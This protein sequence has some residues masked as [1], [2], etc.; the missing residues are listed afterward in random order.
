MWRRYARMFGANPRGDTE[1]ELSFHYEMRV[2]DYMRSSM[3]EA[4]AREAAR[5]RLGNIDAVRRECGDLGDRYVREDRRREWLGEFR[6]DVK[7][8]AR[9][10]LRSP[11]FALVATL[12]LGLGIGV[13]TAVYSV[14]DRVLL[15]PLPYA[16]PEE[17]VNVWE[18]SPQGD[19]HNA[20][21]PGN[22]VEWSTR[23]KSFEA[24]GAYQGPHGVALTG[25][26]EPQ[27][28]NAVSLTPSA[29][30]ALGAAPLLG[31]TMTA[32][33]AKGSGDVVVLS[34]AF[35]QQ[36]FGGDRRVTDRTL[37]LDEA[38]HRI[39]GVMPASFEYPNA[40]VD[41][42][43]PFAVSAVA[44][45]ERR[46]HNYSV[47][48]RLKPGVTVQ[49]ARA[50]MTTL[51]GNLAGEYPQ[52]MKGWGVNVVPLH[53][54]LTADVRTLLWVLF[55]TVGVVLLIACGNLANL[56]LARAVARENEMA[57]RGALGAGRARIARQLLTES[58]LIAISGGALGLILASLTLRGLLKGA[59]ASIPLLQQVA[60]DWSVLGFAAAV[61]VGST[62]V[63]G[64]V[65]ALRLSRANLQSTLRARGAGAIQNARLRGALLVGEVALSV[66]L[67]VSA[68]LLVRSFRQL[69]RTD[70]GYPSRD[71]AVMML[72]LPRSRYVGNEPQIAFYERVIAG[73]NHVPGISTA[74]GTAHPPAS[75][76][77][78]TFS[79][80]IEGRQAANPSGREDPEE[81]HAV[82][83]DFFRTAGI[84]V[85][86]GRS[87][88][89][90]DRADGAPVAIINESLARKHWPIESP[91]GKR[92]SF[93]QG[94]TSWLEIVGV[95]ADTRWESPDTEPAPALY[96]PHAQKTWPW[97]SWFGIVMRLAPGT[98]IEALRPRIQSTLWQIDDQLPMQSLRP[99]DELYGETIARRTFA[100]QLILVFAVLALCL[101]IV[102]LYGL[103]AYTVAQQRQ[104]FGVRLALGARPIAVAGRV[105]ANSLRLA[106]LGIG[107]G[108][109]VAL[110]A[111]RLLST[112]LYGV[113][114]TD[115]LTI[116]VI[117]LVVFATAAAASWLPARRAVRV[118]PL[119]ALRGG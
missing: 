3:S 73:L 15:A 8:G 13:T 47:I 25:D 32:E 16:E 91:V 113:E 84:R 97:M 119:A 29:M 4:E 20:V 1:D 41:V 105:L 11:G 71:L 63:F 48:A 80:G 7:Y 33:D 102:G 116:T 98:E 28:I 117:A 27:Q 31:R 30:Q 59:P 65:P 23:T 26:G 9:V 114:P 61:T 87:F 21:S 10:L 40:E 56:L 67:L 66:V 95:V 44:A 118:D 109:A 94:E 37:L 82:T 99:L 69:Q 74:A 6:Q 60:L 62:M 86:Q 12:T 18:H 64:L 96:I 24:I 42:W 39:I 70:L 100:M 81:L 89:G 108:I 72:D 49:Q 38:P 104:E 54:D 110:G 103:M 53:E 45:T 85:L 36:R 111:T 34:H 46:S 77:T 79:F 2:R 68:G 57:V 107:I 90:R 112:L 75:G 19:D 83:A 115:P 43:R 22:Y 50:E 51:A 35:W 88:D 5:E 93:R 101:S 92:I 17:L 76:Q 106:G 58:L 52:F 55:G 14:V 78:M